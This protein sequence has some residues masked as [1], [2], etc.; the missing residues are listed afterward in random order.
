MDHKV[1]PC[2]PKMFD[3]PLNLYYDH[4][5]LHQR[6]NVRVPMKLEIHERLNIWPALS[7]V[8]VQEFSCEIG[9]KKISYYKSQW[10]IVDMLCFILSKCYC[11]QEG[12]RYNIIFFPKTIFLGHMFK[13]SIY[14]HFWCMSLLLVHV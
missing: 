4:F 11:T 5:N 1:V 2:S 3:W 12:R 10:T 9:K 6:E 14:P 8:M 13:R 7:I